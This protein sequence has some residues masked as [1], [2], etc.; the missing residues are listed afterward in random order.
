MEQQSP[1]IEELLR[2]L[3]RKES[4][5]AMLAPSFPIVFSYPQ[6]VGKLKRLGFKRVIEVARGAQETNRQLLELL[7][8]EPRSR[9]IT[10]PCPAIVR[11]IR[12]KHPELEKYLSPTDSPM[13]AS[14]K[15]VRDE[16]PGS[17]SVFIGPCLVKKLEARENL[18]L[19]ILAITFSELKNLFKEIEM[20]YDISTGDK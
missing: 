5:I 12:S 15:L 1:E 11:L 13:V 6:I 16:F 17:R 7:K 4:L 3:K 8:K 18:R 2:A 14:S 19:N 9:Y 20:V 10:S